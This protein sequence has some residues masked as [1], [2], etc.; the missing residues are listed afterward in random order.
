MIEELL[1]GVRK[2]RGLPQ[3]PEHL[4]ELSEARDRY[5]TLHRSLESASDEGGDGAR[6]PS[7]DRL[8][9]ASRELQASRAAFN[10]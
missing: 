3:S 4:L 7:D 1:D 9:P 10:H 6:Q 2:A 5:R 8:G